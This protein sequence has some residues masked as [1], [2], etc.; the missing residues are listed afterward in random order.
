M[1]AK[2][3]VWILVVC[4]CMSACTLFDDDDDDDTGNGGSQFTAGFV[5][6]TTGPEALSV[7]TLQYSAEG[8]TVTV[9]VYAQDLADA[10]GLSFT[11]VWNPLLFQYMSAAE[12]SFLSTGGTATTFLTSLENGQQGR[13]VVGISR[14]G[15]VAGATGSGLVC[16]V[17]FQAVGT[18]ETGLSYE[19]AFV[20]DSL[21]NALGISN[22]YGGTLFSVAQ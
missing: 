5:P 2:H 7:Y 8:A 16:T 22:W 17:T 1:Q 12:G 9:G 10:Y 19:Q 14:L 6:Q 15:Q 4:L 13:L 3:L 11:L 18:G 21:G 20:L